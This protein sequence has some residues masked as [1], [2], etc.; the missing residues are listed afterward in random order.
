MYSGYQGLNKIH[1]N[2]KGDIFLNSQI[3][4]KYDPQIFFNLSQLLNME[5]W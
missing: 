2:K 3:L 1:R 5:I 4:P